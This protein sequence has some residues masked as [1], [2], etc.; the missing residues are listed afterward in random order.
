MSR[1]DSDNQFYGSTD[2]DVWFDVGNLA[3]EIIIEKAAREARKFSN[4]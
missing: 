1:T 3:E 2:T 4:D